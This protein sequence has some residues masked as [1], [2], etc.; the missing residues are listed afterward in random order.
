MCTSQLAHYTLEFLDV[1]QK[2]HFFVGGPGYRLHGVNETELNALR[3]GD[4]PYDLGGEFSPVRAPSF[5]V[6]EC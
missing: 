3:A 6:V 4:P 5:I 1:K 2:M